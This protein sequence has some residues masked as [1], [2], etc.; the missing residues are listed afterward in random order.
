M[1]ELVKIGI[2]CIALLLLFLFV[3]KNNTN[4]SKNIEMMKN[5]KRQVTQQRDNIMSQN[6]ILES[7]QSNYDVKAAEPMSKNETYKVLDNK[8]ED[9]NNSFG[10]NGNQFPNDC[11]PKDQLS[12]ADLLPGDANS[13]WAKVNPNGQGELGDQNFINAGYHV[14]VNTIGSSL[15]N[16]NLQLRSEP[17]N[18]QVAVGPWQQSTIS[19]DLNRRAMEIGN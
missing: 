10:L 5:Y 11:F 19:P 3:N 4:A 8:V 18:P 13:V 16:S 2:V 17:P 7:T 12:P 14:G 9:P 6:D 15:R 1:T